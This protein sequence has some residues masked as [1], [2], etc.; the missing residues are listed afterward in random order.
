MFLGQ[1]SRPFPE[2]VPWEDIAVVQLD[3]SLPAIL[4]LPDRL[5]ALGPA[6][7]WRMQ[8]RGQEVRRAAV[9]FA[10]I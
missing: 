2:L 6:T 3:T 10:F 5:R 7:V 9:V 8:Q 4:A 1:S